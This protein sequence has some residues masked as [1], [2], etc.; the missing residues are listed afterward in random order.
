MQ[1]KFPTPTTS[2]ERS[3]TSTADCSPRR[4]RHAPTP[5][6]RAPRTSPE[7]DPAPHRHRLDELVS[8]LSGCHPD[9][10]RRAIAATGVGDGADRATATAAVADALVEVSAALGARIAVDVAVVDVTDHAELAVTG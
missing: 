7:P 5:P 6:D 2:E 8:H 9:A 10:A 3:M 4:T 1:L